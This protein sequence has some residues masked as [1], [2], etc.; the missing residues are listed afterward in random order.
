MTTAQFGL[1][2]VCLA[3]FLAGGLYGQRLTQGHTRV[4]EAMDA[5]VYTM[6]ALLYLS[7]ALLMHL[8]TMARATSGGYSH[9]VLTSVTLALLFAVVG[10]ALCTVVWYSFF[11]ML[12]N[13]GFL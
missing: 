7:G 13:I 2:L 3:V 8:E 11:K 9:S 4:T 12:K 6:L 10:T 1:M 5:G